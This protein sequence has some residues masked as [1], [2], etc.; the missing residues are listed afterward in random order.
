M[1]C[2]QL[3][4]IPY[5]NA[6]FLFCGR[7]QITMRALHFDK[8][9]GVLYLKRLDNGLF[10]WPKDASEVRPLSRHMEGSLN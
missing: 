7:K 8:N 10:Q 9:G 1:E 4:G 6:L 3:F 5:A 2:W